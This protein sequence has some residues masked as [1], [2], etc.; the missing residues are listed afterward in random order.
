MFIDMSDSVQVSVRFRPM[1]RNET[2]SKNIIQ[3]LEPQRVRVNGKHYNFD[4]VFNTDTNNETAYELPCSSLL[5]NVIAGYNSTIMT[6]GQTGAGKTHTL[7]G[8]PADPGIIP[9]LIEQLFTKFS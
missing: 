6:Y 4:R 5:D 8:I 7:T 3:K 9:R 1:N 2:E